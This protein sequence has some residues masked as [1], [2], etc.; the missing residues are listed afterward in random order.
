M[1]FKNLRE[2]LEKL[3]EIANSETVAS[4]VAKKLLQKDVTAHNV[5]K[6][7]KLL[8]DYDRNR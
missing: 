3:E 8:E 5:I 2:K 6:I 7:Q 4:E 1:T